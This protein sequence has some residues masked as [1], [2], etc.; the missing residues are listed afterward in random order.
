MAATVEDM[1]ADMGLIAAN[2]GAIPSRLES[3]K[4]R[5]SPH[6]IAQLHRLADRILRQAQCLSL[7]LPSPIFWTPEMSQKSDEHMLR[8]RSAIEAAAQG[9]FKGAILKRNLIAIFHGHLPSAIDSPSV[10]SRKERKSDKSRELRGLGAGSIL[11]WAVSLPPSSWE[12]IDQIIFDDVVTRMDK[13]ATDNKSVVEIA[14]H[15]RK[16]IRDLGTEEPLCKYASYRNFVQEIEELALNLPQQYR[17]KRRRLCQDDRAEYPSPS[18]D[19]HSAE[20]G[21]ESADQMIRMAPGPS[22]ETSSPY[23]DYDTSLSQVRY[24]V[25][26]DRLQDLLELYSAGHEEGFQPIALGVPVDND[27]AFVFFSVSRVAAIRYA[28]NAGLNEWRDDWLMC[29]N[30]KQET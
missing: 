25:P 15:V 27:P 3:E 1:L 9:E 20:Y 11:A 29:P 4:I 24:N 10:K 23:E 6:E 12:E 26:D 19:P 28:F 8:A 13:A 5:P 2:I 14:L 22:K 18:P 21:F 16:T 7:T 17:S 30:I